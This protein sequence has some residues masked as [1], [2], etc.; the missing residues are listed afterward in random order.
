LSVIA[1]IPAR[2]ES[3]RF[4]GKPLAHETGKYLVQ[5]VYEQVSRATLIDQVII[6]TD[7]PRIE[8]ASRQFAAPCCMTRPDHPSG[9]DRIAQVAESISADIFVNVQGDEPEVEPENIDRAV[10]LLNQDSAADISTLAARFSPAE[11]INDP[12]IVKVV[13]DSRG[14]ALYFS[15]WPIPYQRDKNNLPDLTLYRKHLGLYAYRSEVLMRLCRL[16]PSTLEKAEKLEQLRA[17]ENGLT[18][19][20]AEVAHSGLGID[21]P[22]QYQAFVQRYKKSQKP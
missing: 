13:V 3:S 6:A 18:I 20:V 21:T 10:E 2:Y 8:N 11:D 4:R 1:V 15:R 12:N 19:A 9:T 5:H 17:L 14:H 7:D 16:E 22:Q